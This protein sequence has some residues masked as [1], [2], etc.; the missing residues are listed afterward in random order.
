MPDADPNQTLNEWMRTN[1]I[2]GPK[3]MCEQGGCGCCTVSLI[4][5]GEKIK[6]I[7]SVCIIKG[8]GRGVGR[9]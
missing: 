3:V 7:A 4:K 2:T 6:A 1:C 8:I 5:P 9:G